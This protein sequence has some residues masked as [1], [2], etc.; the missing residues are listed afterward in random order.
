[1]AQ[2]ER[3]LFSIG[4]YGLPPVVAVNRFPDDPQAEV[5]LV[6][7]WC[8]GHGVPAA[9]CTGY[10]DGAAGSGA[11]AEAVGAV[12]DA[13]DAA[14]PRPWHPYPADAGYAEKV[15]AVARRVYGAEAV[16]V[17]PDAA[18]EL[19]RI[20][21]AVGTGLPVCIA[22]THLSLSDDPTRRGVP[23]G[24]SLTVRD[25]RLA[26]GAG[27]VVVSTGSIVTMPGLPRHPAALRVRVGPDGSISG[28]MAD[29]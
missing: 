6:L 14:P 18:R 12:L 22:K 21:A 13:T 19:A 17:T 1:M 26:A 2:L 11:I 25:A 23:Q 5:D 16:D 27:F 8:S 29:R 20:T 4:A 10:S 9:A 3:H 7:R 15:L 28:L 24:F